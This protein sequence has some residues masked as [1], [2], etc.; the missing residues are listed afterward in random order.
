MSTLSARDLLH[1]HR[2]WRD[3]IDTLGLLR[4]H[5][6]LSLSARLRH[7]HNISLPDSYSS[8]PDIPRVFANGCASFQNAI[9]QL[10]L[11]DEAP[12]DFP[13]LW[14]G[15]PALTSSGAAPDLES[16][17]DSVGNLSPEACQQKVIEPFKAHALEVSQRLEE[18]GGRFRKAKECAITASASRFAARLEIEQSLR[19]QQAELE[20]GR[21]EDQS[22]RRKRLWD[23][24]SRA[25]ANVQMTE[26]AAEW[27]SRFVDALVKVGK[28]IRGQRWDEW[29]KASAELN[30]L[31]KDFAEL[32]L[33]GDAKQI[34]QAVKLL[35]KSRAE[36]DNLREWLTALASDWPKVFD[37][38]WL[39][40]K[41]NRAFPPQ[42]VPTAVAF[43]PSA[44][45][46]C[47]F[48]ASTD[49][50]LPAGRPTEYQLL[51]S[52]M[53]SV[54]ELDEP[55]LP[56]ITLQNV[57]DPIRRNVGDLTDSQDQELAAKLGIGPRD[58]DNLNE[59]QRTGRM[60]AALAAGPEKCRKDELAIAAL[61]R[62]DGPFGTDGFQ[63]RG[64]EVRFGR[65]AKRKALV[66]A[67]WDENT[68]QPRAARPVQD[69]LDAVYGE[70]HDTDDATFRQLC[71]DARSWLHASGVPLTIE[72]LQGQVQLTPRPV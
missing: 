24:L 40:W 70:D 20:G 14:C 48:N 52:A 10:S 43:S 13:W 15:G 60:R 19:E 17:L 27:E 51:A 25:A 31:L 29:F 3:V 23:L 4:G 41:L 69:V 32:I 45:A 64:V 56:T 9:G 71:A 38:G 49:F 30:D 55:P 35:P 59:E 11:F 7:V 21:L 42:A 62:P 16:W 6:W 5:V 66:L 8:D 18:V 28:E 67:L 46:C 53:L 36:S 57:D 2:A 33:N 47:E 26:P 50:P 37:Q 63:Y 72:T 65:A 34:A 44:G 22:Q 68:H 1:F 58:W 61:P 12:A 39:R 54:D